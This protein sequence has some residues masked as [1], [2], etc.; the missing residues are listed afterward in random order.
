MRPFSSEWWR[1]ERRRARPWWLWP[2]SLALTA[3]FAG[4][5]VWCLYKTLW[6]GATSTG[7][8]LALHIPLFV[9]PS[10]APWTAQRAA[11]RA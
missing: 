6:L 5:L 2:Y 11:K 4:G 9:V 7:L 1:H 10:R 3:Y 8:V